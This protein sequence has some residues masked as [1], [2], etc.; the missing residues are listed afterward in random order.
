[1]RPRYLS[2]SKIEEKRVKNTA[3]GGRRKRTVTTRDRDTQ[4]ET[5]REGCIPG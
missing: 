5:V 4:I 1:M 3:G 2:S